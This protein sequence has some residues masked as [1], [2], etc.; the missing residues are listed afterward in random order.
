MRNLQY[1]VFPYNA[2]TISAGQEDATGRT[3]AAT[4]GDV[5]A[6]NNDASEK[7]RTSSRHRIFLLSPA[8][9]SGIRGQRLLHATA[10]SELAVR[11]RQTGVR[12][13][14]V[15]QHISSLYFRGKLEYAQR[16]RNPPQ[17]VAG[18]Q[19]ITGNG[20]M[21]PETLIRF[22]EFRELSAIS[23]DASNERYRQSLI[24]DLM[25]LREMAGV[26]VDIILLGSIATSKYVDPIANVFGERV[27]VPR[28]FVGCGDMKRGSLLL[29]CCAQGTELEYVSVGSVEC[30]A[31]RSV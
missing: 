6:L 19:I 17:P 29:R 26:H 16:F 23:I 15:Y 13:G 10:P 22:D 21:L 12:L 24:A 25:R 20:L 4:L 7:L 1:N 31:A 30:A 9:A 11:L 14:D 27:L 8:N 28:D 2:P 3:D 5:I 18:V